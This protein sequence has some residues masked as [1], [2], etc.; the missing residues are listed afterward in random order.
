MRLTLTAVALVVVLVGGLVF[1]ISRNFMSYTI[2]R[3]WSDPT[4]VYVLYKLRRESVHVSLSDI[5]GTVKSQKDELRLL[6]L[7]KEG[8]ARS[9]TIKLAEGDAATSLIYQD[10]DF[11]LTRTKEG[12]TLSVGSTRA[13]LQPC[14]V[15]WAATGAVRSVSGLFYC[16]VIY[17]TN[18]K[19]ILRLPTN[20][21][22]ED[23]DRSRIEQKVEPLN[24]AANRFVVAFG[25]ESLMVVPL[26]QVKS[27]HGLAINSWP[28][29][30]DH[31]S[32]L[33]L[34]LAASDGTYLPQGDA[35]AYSPARIVLRPIRAEDRRLLLCTQKSC[36][37]VTIPWIYSYVIVDESA[38]ECIFFRQQ[39]LTKPVV[40]IRAVSF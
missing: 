6:R 31:R 19:A 13:D 20:I 3:M 30:G 22:S 11:N 36:Q 37:Q 38:R 14:D 17:D 16:G 9:D 39:D 29:N 26:A 32:S 2:Q 28:I 27:S 24:S 40:E 35:L 1:G 25:E 7:S 5:N 23:A 4:S 15:V 18:G 21:G 8:F 10:S 33:A 12:A 34:P